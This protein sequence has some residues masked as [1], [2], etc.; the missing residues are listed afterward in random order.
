VRV[1]RFGSEAEANAL[2]AE[3]TDLGYTG[4]RTVYTG[5]DGGRT[6]GPWVVH[7]LRVDP[8]ASGARLR[9]SLGPRWCRRGSC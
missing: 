2:R 7:V 4:L 8:T 5:E 6:T 1:G 9:R 3:L